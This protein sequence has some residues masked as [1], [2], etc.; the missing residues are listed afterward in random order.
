MFLVRGPQK[1]R[2][3]CLGMPGPPASYLKHSVDLLAPYPL[4]MREAHGL[5]VH[6]CLLPLVFVLA[7]LVAGDVRDSYRRKQNL[8]VHRVFPEKVIT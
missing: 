1:D 2:T 7:P 5:A 8:C 6:E 3:H 4:G